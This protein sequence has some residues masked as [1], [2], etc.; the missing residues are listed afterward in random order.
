[1]S[2]VL[3]HNDIVKP[4]RVQVIL[5]QPEQVMIAASPVIPLAPVLDMPAQKGG[6]A[7][8]ILGLFRHRA[9]IAETPEGVQLHEPPAGNA[10]DQTF[11]GH[12]MVRL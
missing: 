4:K 8:K 11:S 9:R 3:V 5:G 7:G 1:M 2:T 10:Y 6:I 12:L